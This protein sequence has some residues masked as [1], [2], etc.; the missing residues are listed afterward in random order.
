MSAQ[1]VQQQPEDEKPKGVIGAIKNTLFGGEVPSTPQTVV[2][3]RMDRAEVSTEESQS[4]VRR[5]RGRVGGGGGHS[6][7]LLPTAFGD[8]ATSTSVDGLGKALIGWKS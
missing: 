2:E 3:K 7:L 1:D 8:G 6:R 5:Q 4:E